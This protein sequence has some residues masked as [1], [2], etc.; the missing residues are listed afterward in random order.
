[1]RKTGVEVIGDM[2]WGTHFCLFYETTAD[3]LEITVAYCKAGLEN[4]EFCLWVVAEPL[5]VEE[6]MRALQRAVPDFDRYFADHSIEIVAARDWYLQNGIFD[7]NRVIRGWNEKLARASA[8]GYAGVRVTGVT[9]WLE[10][11]DWKDFC[12]YEDSL[13]QAVA[14]QRLAVLCTYP[15]AACGAAEILDVVR[16]H[17][18]ALTKR[19]GAWDVIETAGH[20]QA[21]AEIKCLNEE[22]EQRVAERTRQLTAVNNELTK[23][24]ILRQRAEEALRR[25]EAYLAEAQRVSHTGS[26]GWS[27]SSGEIVWSDETFRIFQYDRAHTPALEPILQRTH[28]EDRAFVQEKINQVVLERKAFEFEHRLLMPDSS[29][30]HVRVVGHPSA[31]DDSRSFELV[32]AVMDITE[33][34]QVEQTLREREAYLEE[35]QRLTHTGSGAWRVPGWDAL[36]LSDEWYRIYGFDP[37]RGLVAW[38]ERL[39]RMHPEDRGKVQEAKDRAIR[40][41]SDYEV[42]HRILLP[43]G[44]L[45]HTHTVGHPVLN[46]Y[47]EV[48]Q[49]VCTM[50]DITERK[51]AEEAL[52]RSEAYLA[53]A[54]KLSH[55]G[56]WACKIATR[57]MIHSS[58]EHRRL[59]GLDAERKE[60]PLLDE[61][62]QRIHPED[63]DR[64]VGDLEKAI[65]AG[66]NVEANFRVVLPEGTTRYMYGIGH[67]V[68]RESGNTGEFVG[69]VMDVTDR[70]QSEALRNGESRILEMIALDFP[71]EETLEKL[72]RVM[73]S[74]FDG[75]LCSVLFLDEDG[76][77]LR[78]A[79]APNLPEPYL[80]AIDGISIG[81]KAGSCGTA[82]YLGEPVFVTDI[83]KDP[84]WEDYRAQ[85]EP[86][87]FRACWS[88]PI[89]AHSGKPLG[90]L[91]MY[92]REPRA[93]SPTE[94][95]ALEMA[96]H[97]AG[98]A[99]ERRLIHEQLRRS[100]SYLTEA[101]RLSHTG[102]W[103]FNGRKAIYWSEENFR[104]WGFDPQ[105]GLP[106]REKILQRIHPEDRER[107]LEYVN[108]TLREKTDYAVEFRVVL[109]DGTIKHIQGLGH[110]VFSASG[111]LIEVVGT[112]LDV[113]ERKRADE[114]RE[115]LR[116]AQAE[117][118]HIN[119]VTTMGE[120][121]ASLA[122]EIKQPI[123]AAVTDARTCVR[124]LNRDEPNLVE[125]RE[126][127]SRIATDVLRAAE[128]ISRISVLFKK[129]SAQQEE[130]VDMNE[131]IQ[132]M[133]ILL[134]SEAS[135]YSI[136]IR[137]ELANDLPA[138]KADR[139][140]LHQVLMN[141][142][143]NG[144]EAMKETGV[145]GE[146]TIKS[147]RH[148]NRQL[149]VG[150]S[151]TGMGLKKEHAEQ[152][153]NAFFTTK[154]QGTGMGL[155]ISR[156][157]IESH[158]GRLWATSNS[159][160]GAT[161]QFTL[162]TEVPPLDDSRHRR[163][164]LSPPVSLP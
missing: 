133:M 120:L 95:R 75:S 33:A 79:V 32:G 99:I 7:L 131:L 9:A 116:Q 68:A 145:V 86:C 153:F 35:A 36:Y 118:A 160:H 45:K 29:V 22:L 69:T 62:F 152:I 88:T 5:V 72:V 60:L 20:K 141:L 163:S 112:Q 127:A 3:L 23:E 70:K 55:T 31:N 57:E 113:T 121:T 110:P 107:M 158:G 15:L 124:W 102:S 4:Q 114:E 154:P 91:A 132:E 6:A 53:E 42:E 73:E 123:A 40:E 80:K 150:V 2:P 16:T 87:G 52:L 21:K 74:Q 30:K 63:R 140:Q 128:I 13:N 81:P 43:D 66:T 25:S 28:P 164:H 125:A 94:I 151:D 159:G 98:I 19:R 126:A 48:E 56:S 137:G 78:H 148:E 26:F 85:A 54:Q 50:M 58:E 24:V 8:R 129:G 103:A 134:R 115:R 39:Q 89:L 161:F 92:Y 65:G 138:V 27:V 142:M 143:L 44:T 41:R 162:P 93:P 139:V 71:L 37:K 11:K 135:R 111:E 108:K 17:Q 122:H 49:F 67:P 61:F 101:Q 109:P 64:T 82:M 157:I 10:K 84:L 119:R 149:L 59:F 136:S 90:S 46:A 156:S 147:Q 12:E 130:W 106:D 77:H 155:P 144:I 97:L 34:K 51:Q 1:M 47:G 18:F 76:Q 38:H 96:T 100:E 104:I 146:L 105:Q 83:L 14:N 117:L